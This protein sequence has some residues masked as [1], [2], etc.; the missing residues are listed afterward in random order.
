MLVF[1]LFVNV[2]FYLVS[3]MDGERVCCH[4]ELVKTGP[5]LIWWFW[6]QST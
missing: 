3:C 6:Q 4:Q 2:S 5:I 1:L